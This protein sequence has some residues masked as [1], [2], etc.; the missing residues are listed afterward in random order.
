MKMQKA[1]YEFILEAAQPIC[2]LAE[3]IG[4]EGIL[5]RESIRQKGGGFFDV[6]I[7]TGDTMRHGL[8]EAAAYAYLDAAGMLDSPA[9]SEAA[10]RLLF[11]GGMVTGKGDAGTISLD[12]YREMTELIPSLRLF[13]GCTNSRVIPGQLCVENALLISTESAHSIARTCGTDPDG[14]P[15]VFRWATGAGEPIESARAHVAEEQRVRMDPTLIPEKRLLLT[16]DAQVSLNA[17]LTSGE[18]AH[19]ASDAITADREK[20]TMMP[21]RSEVVKRGALF[22]WGFEATCYTPLDLDTLHVTAAAFLSNMKVGGKRATGHGLMR[23]VAAMGVTIPEMSRPADA[24]ASTFGPRVGDIF[25]EHVA[26][27]AERIREILKTV[28]A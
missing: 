16:A 26:A 22:F 8:R 18:K 10:L 19:E 24:L 28:D 3:N 17:R 5:M 6:P 2:H 27:R 4:N 25:R 23:A 12:L 1:R 9:L 21:R 20:S 15:W 7:I 14:A 11:A 13:G